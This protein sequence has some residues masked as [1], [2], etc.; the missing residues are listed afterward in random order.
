MVE[1][2]FADHHPFQAHDLAF[3]DALPVLMTEKDAVKCTEFADPRLWYVPIAAQ[4]SESQERELL[5][6]VLRR[7]GLDAIRRG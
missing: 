1:H 2:P 3:G 4:F 7:I 6:R 5:L